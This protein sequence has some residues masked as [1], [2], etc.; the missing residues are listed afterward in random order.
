MTNT[1]RL[2]E[3]EKLMAAEAR[4][5][6]LFEEIERR[7]LITPG[8][9]EMQL[10][11][12]IFDLAF[13]LQGI[14]TFWHKR[15]VRAGKN[16]LLPYAENPPDLVLREN[17]ILF[18]DFGPVYED[19]EADLGRTYVLGNDPKMVQLKNDTDRLW[20]EGV[21]YFQT[22]YENLT[23]ADFYAY[24]CELA[25]ENGREFGNI[26]CGHLIG[27]FPHEKLSGEDKRN[28]LHPANFDP[29]SL[30]DLAG[31]RRFWIYEMHL[32]DKEH[33]IGAFVEGIIPC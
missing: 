9:T 10:N 6:E 8:I 11:R 4:A 14:R 33:E 21:E 23:G 7:Q 19:W 26:H 3:L 5:V 32:I 25:N 1:S 28:Y 30:P 2:S 31:R 20:K 24:T 17:E 16:T 27:N 22:N 12:A 15:I 29:V 18:L 13:E